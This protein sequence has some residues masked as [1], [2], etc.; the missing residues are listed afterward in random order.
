ML[1]N[2]TIESEGNENS[3]E[4]R[5][6]IDYSETNLTW[7]VSIKRIEDSLKFEGL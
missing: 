7:S 5:V 2:S 1:K 4:L 6:V 3:I